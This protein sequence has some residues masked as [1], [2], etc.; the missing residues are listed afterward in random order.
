MVDATSN[1]DFTKILKIKKSLWPE[2]STDFQKLGIKIF[3]RAPILKKKYYK[4]FVPL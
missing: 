4:K 2:F 1:I 3:D